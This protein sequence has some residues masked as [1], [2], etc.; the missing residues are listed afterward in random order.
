MMP[1][2]QGGGAMIDKVSFEK[3]TFNGLPNKFEAGTPHIA[4]VICLKSALEYV[5]AIGLHNIHQYEDE[6]LEYATPK[7][8]EITGLKI[9]GE[10]KN[11]AAVI[12]F[13]MDGVHPQ[14]LGT[15]LDQQGIAVRT[16]HHCTQPL[17]DFYQVNATTRAS[18][19]FYNTKEEIDLL[20]SAIIKA[21]E[22]L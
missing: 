4:G 21:K 10:A 22:F 15:L 20:T 3:T 1:P 9:I 6:L 16:G 19:C 17:M 5:N 12:S 13:V 18:F 8:K 2:Y 14:D 7:L 11:K